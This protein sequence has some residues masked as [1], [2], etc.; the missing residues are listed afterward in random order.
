[1]QI[2]DTKKSL[3]NFKYIFIN[4][5]LYTMCSSIVIQKEN[6]ANYFIK[7]KLLIYK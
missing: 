4:L 6:F 2:N 3:R 1:M 7:R 5:K